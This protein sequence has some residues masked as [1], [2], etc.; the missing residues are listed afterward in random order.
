MYRADYPN[1]AKTYL[2]NSESNV[3]CD[4][5]NW[6]PSIHMPKE[7]A[8]IFLSVT[9]VRVERLQDITGRECVKEGIPESSLM[10]MGEDFTIGQFHDLWDST[11]K[12]KDRDKYGWNANPLVWVIEF[13]KVEIEKRG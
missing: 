13:E 5:P 10:E 4:L 9:D 12:P 7:A 6:R 3:V 11:V 2:F 1:G 8:R